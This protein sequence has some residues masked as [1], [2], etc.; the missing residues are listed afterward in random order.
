MQRSI[1]SDLRWQPKLLNTA[2]EQNAE[3]ANIHKITTW[4]QW[5]NW[6]HYAVVHSAGRTMTMQLLDS[7]IPNERLH[8]LSSLPQNY[9]WLTIH[10]ISRKA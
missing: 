3:K 1:A 5:M 9:P 8:G 4:W 7:N 2:D 6:M 10:E